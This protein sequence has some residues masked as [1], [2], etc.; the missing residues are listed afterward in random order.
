MS[1]PLHELTASAAARLIASR[2]ITSELLV[3]A[4]LDRID[5]REDTVRAWAFLDAEQALAEA[6]QRDSEDHKGPLHGIPVGIKDIIDTVDM[7]TAYG[8]PIYQGTRPA[9]DATCVAQVRAAGGVILGKTVSSEFATFHPGA[10]RNP[11]NPGHTPGGSSSGSAAAVADGMVPLAFGT[12]TAGSVIRP[13][14]YCGTA[15]YKCTHGQFGLAGVKMVAQSLD[16]LGVFARAIGDIALMRSALIGAPPD[17]KSRATAPRIGLCR[18]PQWP[19]AAPET[20]RAVEGTAEKLR[21]EGAHVEDIAMPDPFPTLVDLQNRVML[22]EMARNL[23][24]EYDRHHEALSGKLRGLIEA[25]RSVS[26]RNYVQ[27]L[28]TRDRCRQ[29]LADLFI[30]FD[31]LLA[32]SAPGVAP[33]GLEAT[34]NPLFNRMWTF[35]QVPCVNLPGHVGPDGL[36]VGVQLIGGLGQDDALLATAAWMERHVG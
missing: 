30:G 24:F 20:Q 8:S 15:A 16:S 26:Y 22:F 28:T 33:D 3:Q 1:A 29:M 34:G 4:C 36:P 5:E 6:R 19:E 12:Q 10:T 35:L 17:I 23:G 14:S 2:E 9:W 13:A 18:T 7:P 25:G 21:G 11:R 32:P 27:A 31:A